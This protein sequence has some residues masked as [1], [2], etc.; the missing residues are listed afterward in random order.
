[1]EYKKPELSKQDK[2]RANEVYK[3]LQLNN[4]LTK[5]QICG[6]LGW[7]Y[8]SSNDRRVRELL[9]IIGKLQPLISTSDSKGYRLAKNEKDFRDAEHQWAEID[10]R[11]AE[12]EAR[13]KPLIKFC[14]KYGKII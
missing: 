6:Y 1:M 12:L 9:A 4:I 2:E 13:R 8:N 14:E 5:E 10:S 7:K 3:Q 11:I